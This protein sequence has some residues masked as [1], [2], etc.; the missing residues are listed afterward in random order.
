MFVGNGVAVGV[1]VG[2]DV[3]VAVGSDVGVSVGTAVSVA[4]ASGI[5]VSVGVVVSSGVGVNSGASAIMS[6]N[7]SSRSQINPKNSDGASVRAA[8][9]RVCQS[10]V[11][12]VSASA[13]TCSKSANVSLSSD[14]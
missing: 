8:P 11:P 4:V 10:L 7:S 6:E 12:F 9:I 14:C 5:A 1:S 3:S 2:K 13:S